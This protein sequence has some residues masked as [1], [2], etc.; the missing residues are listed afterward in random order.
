[1]SEVFWGPDF[2]DPAQPTTYVESSL[3][4]RHRACPRSSGHG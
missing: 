3:V 2:P 4:A 1:M